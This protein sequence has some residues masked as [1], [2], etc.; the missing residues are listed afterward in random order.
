MSLAY[1]NILLLKWSKSLKRHIYPTTFLI[2]W[3]CNNCYKI[4]WNIFDGSAKGI[5]NLLNILITF[6]SFIGSIVHGIS[7]EYICT[8]RGFQKKFILVCNILD[9]ALQITI[10][11]WMP[12]ENWCIYP[13]IFYHFYLLNSKELQA[14][15]PIASCY[16]GLYPNSH[17]ITEILHHI[18]LLKQ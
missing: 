4:M 2:Q 9:M 12:H 14:A 5:S 7:I 8:W 1:Q 15:S 18:Y 10:S 13:L 16:K 3:S 11:I 17:Y 6:C